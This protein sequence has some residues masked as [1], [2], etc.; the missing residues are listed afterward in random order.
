[1]PAARPEP[2]PLHGLS[3]R[4][5]LAAGGIVIAAVLATAA[6]S[7]REAQTAA[8]SMLGVRPGYGPASVSAV[9]NEAAIVRRIWMPGLDDGYNPQGLAVA[10]DSILVAAYRSES[11]EVH[12]GPCRVFRVDTA[13]GRATGQLDVPPPCGHAGGLATAAAI[14]RFYV[15][16]THT[17][18]MAA[19]GGAFDDGGHF[20]TH[21]LGPGL[22]GALAVSGTDAIWLGTYREDEPG[23]L[24]RFT[25]AALDA[26]PD[27]AALNASDATFQIAIPSHAQGAAID[28]GGRLWV[29]R[30]TLRWGELDRLDAASGK[31]EREY[32]APPGLEGIAFD[33]AG[34]L[35]AVS[36]AGA[37]HYTEGWRG[38]VLPFYPL[39]V[40]IDP[41][42]LK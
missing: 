40:A 24:Y 13:T 4:G 32:Q 41:E 8:A 10:G 3:R 18:F 5:L 29:A 12:R 7:L 42:R 39:I 6:V 30:S 15:A 20:A 22:V 26:M 14:K 19:L 17:F 9:P 11:P 31:V 28:A 23:W 36:E 33:A 27:G 2:D 16:D 34:R 1:V 21:P 38:F 35:W 37:R 25:A